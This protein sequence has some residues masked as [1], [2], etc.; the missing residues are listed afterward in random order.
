MAEYKNSIR[1][2]IALENEKDVNGR[3]QTL[4]NTLEKNKINLDIN[5]ENSDVAKQLEAL[6]NLANNFKNSLGGK[7][8]LGNINEIINQTVVQAE[9]L[10][11]ELQKV[12]R[13][14]LGNGLYKQTELVAT[15]LGEITKQTGTVQKI[16]DEFNYTGSAVRTATSDLVGYDNALLKI[17]KAQSSLSSLKLV[18][19]NKVS[20][21]SSNLNANDIGSNNE[22]KN[23]LNQVKELENEEKKLQ[24]IQTQAYSE[25][26]VLQKE[27]YS[28]KQNLITA[29][30][31][32]KSELESRLVTVNQLKSAQQQ[33]IQ[34]NNLTNQQK[35]LELT[36]QQ[37]KLQ[38]QL[39]QARAKQ[40]DVSNSNDLKT[41][42][43]EQEL[44]QKQEQAYQQINVLK[45]NG[46]INTSEI[47]KLQELVRSA[48]SIKEINSALSSIGTSTSRESS[49]ST[50]T[51]QIQEAQVKLEQMKSTFGSKLPSG[52]I[53]STEAELN[54][55]LADLKQVDGTNF[56]GIK[57]SLN[58]VNS[59]MKQT[60]SETQQLVSSLNQAGGSSFF[61]SMSN[62]LGKIGVFYGVQQVVQEITS[63]LKS[64]GEYTLVM[65][66]A[67][68]NM[69]MITGKSKSEIGSL[70]NDYKQLGEQLHTTNVEMMGGMEEITR[71]GIQGDEGK[72]LMSSAIIGSKI[73]GQTTEQTTQQLIAIKNAFD[74]TGQSMQNVVDM[75]SKMD[76]VSASSFAEIS[77]AIQRTAF[78]AQEAGTPLS[79]LIAY[80]TTVSEK[81]RKSASTIGE[82]F[83]TIYSRYS[84][85]KLGNLDDDGKNINDTELAINYNLWL[86]GVI[87]FE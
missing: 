9:K 84:N 57:N 54:K 83:K 10:N 67:F 41:L 31:T 81:T 72:S 53:S 73:S 33:N 42:Q 34:D 4:I 47:S 16:G 49:I 68:T 48:S 71:A 79:N 82:S 14:D 70:V 23:L 26:A 43:Q 1:L 64:A 55:L 77:T 19:Q 74:M 27:E 18:D 40:T 20:N 63:Q 86:N 78:S 30:G 76:N 65:D 38:E 5:I 61:S 17:E 11:G 87:H 15:G 8:S 39:N 12:S 45:A 85:I 80:I 50:L 52:F 22:L 13:T 44:L 58:S 62:F 29:D 59:S 46:V 28:L 3:L 69:Q 36:N 25:M 6:T 21:L 75:I 2:G 35:E 24:Q 60:T 56:T 51:K 32:Y 7:V 37:V 66:K